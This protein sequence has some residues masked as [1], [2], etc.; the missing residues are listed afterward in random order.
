MRGT[1]AYPHGDAGLSRGVG[2]SGS[3]NTAV[4]GAADAA[5][6][7]PSAPE[8][9]SEIAAADAHAPGPDLRSR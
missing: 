2:D 1:A 9:D 4:A 6:H 5:V 3:S 8:A 7:A